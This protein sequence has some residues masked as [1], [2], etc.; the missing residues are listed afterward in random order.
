MPTEA[1]GDGPSGGGCAGIS[2]LV[3]AALGLGTAVYAISRDTLV[4]AVWI[5]GWGLVWRAAKRGP[6]NVDTA[7]NPAPPPLPERGPEATPQVSMVRDTAHPNRWIVA[8]ESP[9]MRYR[10][11]SRDES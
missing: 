10:H 5:I 1:E 2:V 3:A 7:P 6:K 11:E 9:W 4:I 8:T